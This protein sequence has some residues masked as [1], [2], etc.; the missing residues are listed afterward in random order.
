MLAIVAVSMLGLGFPYEP[1][2]VG[3]TL[4]TV[5]VPSLLMTAWARPAPPDRRMLG[6]IARFVL[7]AGVVTAV[8]AVALYTVAYTLV[9]S[10]LRE[11]L[12]PLDAVQRFEAYTGVAGGDDSFVALA[13]VGVAQTAL[14]S[15]TSVTAFALLLFLE[16]P[17]RLFTGWASVSSDKRPALLALGL[18]TTL[19]AVLLTPPLADYFQL[20]RPGGFMLPMVALT[21]VL[22]FF[23]L[24]ACW[25]H[26]LLDRL[27][28]PPRP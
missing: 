28:G 23:T 3:L 10:G 2:Q 1:A 22:W 19:F 18:L 9:R 16:P 14:S 27:L 24:R 8:F 13:S 17:S 5:G 26:G 25:R 4:F 7:P 15:F 11:G 20:L 6:R 12:V 21:T